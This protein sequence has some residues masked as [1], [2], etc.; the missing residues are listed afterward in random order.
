MAAGAETPGGDERTEVLAEIDAEHLPHR[1]PRND[2]LKILVRLAFGIGLLALLIWRLPGVTP[3]ELVPDPSVEVFAWIAA[4]T[5]VHLGAYVLQALR[6][7]EVSDT[8]GIH[9]PFRRM[10]SHLLTGEFVSNALPTSFGGDV[11]RVIRQGND[12][13]DYADAFAATVIE[14]LTGWLVLPL[15]TFAALAA[16]PEYRDL[17]SVTVV[18]ALVGAVTLVALGTI[19]ALAAHP[20]AAGRLVGRTGWRRYLAAVHLGVLAFRH[21]R[22]QALKVLAAGVAFQLAQVVTVWMCARALGVEEV[23]FLAALA[24]FPPTAI[25]Q[26]LPVTLGGLGV[27]EAAFVY[28]FS[29]IGVSNADAIALGLLVYVVFIVSSLAGAPSFLRGGFAGRP[30]AGRG[31]AAGGALG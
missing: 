25:V 17:G 5:V 13:G 12:A 27:R 21:R 15:L 3:S 6:W 10:L 31:K 30:A 2:A 7:A 9:L 23:G 20:R 22:P 8:L 19:L 16:S 18:A 4:A 1:A 14:R 29:A 11:V 26:N 28:F 24:F